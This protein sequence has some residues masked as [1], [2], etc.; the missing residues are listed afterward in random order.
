MSLRRFVLAALL[1]LL[2]VQHADAKEA[3][4]ACTDAAECSTGFCVD[5]VC[6]DESC[7]AP[8]V[9]CRAM[10][11]TSLADDG[12]CGFALSGL[13]A[14]DD[15]AASDAD[16]CGHTGACDGSGACQFFPL[17]TS[18]G[19]TACTANN[20]TGWVCD[21]QGSCYHQVSA[22]PC[23][24]Y[25]CADDACRSPCSGPSDCLDSGS[26]CEGGLCK[27]KRRAG[28]PCDTPSACATGFCVD[29][30][31]CDSVCTG[32]CEAC[33]VVGSE[34]ACRP[35]AGVPEG[36]RAPCAGAGACIGT[37]DGSDRTA[38][39]YPRAGTECAPAECLGDALQPRSTCDGAGACVVPSLESCGHYACEVSA[40][41]CFVSCDTN[42]ACAVGSVCDTG[43]RT[44]AAVL[45]PR[46]KDS[47]TVIDPAG[48]EFSCAPYTCAAG[49][50]RQRC[51]TEAECAAGAECASSRCVLSASGSEAVDGS[52]P[53]M[54]PTGPASDGGDG[55]CGCRVVAMNRDAS[56]PPMALIAAA[57]GA[58]GLA[59]RSK[60][61]RSRP[62]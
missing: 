36:D 29:G 4:D 34:G 25:V 10:L 2:A 17:G 11:K 62:G 28:A 40:G 61:P 52:L 6:C 22:L 1:A 18:C 31:C 32:Q 5:G 13:D 20:V 43:V 59:R 55:G 15:C 42:A 30:F 53:S 60:A 39:V 24:P 3:G 23:A 51:S 38:C 56:A 21:G 58:V 48:A 19:A 9:A 49:A 33:D 35:I 45:Q 26:F 37:C 27:P 57:A 44:C 8:C 50:C 46:C 54:G 47:T 16:T 14:H 41:A 7:G 12:K